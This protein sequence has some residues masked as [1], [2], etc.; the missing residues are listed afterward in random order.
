MIK[1]QVPI[2]KLNEIRVKMKIF[3][4]TLLLITIP[5][6]IILSSSCTKRVTADENSI[7]GLFPAYGVDS[8]V[9]IVNWNVLFS[10]SSFFSTQKEDMLAQII[11]S[12]DVDIIAVQEFP[13]DAEMTRLIAKTNGYAGIINPDTDGFNQNTGYIYK[14]S[15]VTLLRSAPIYTSDGSAFPRSPFTAD[16]V[17]QNSYGKFDVHLVTVHL[18]A[19]SGAT[20]DARRRD[21]NEKLEAYVRDYENTHT[22]KDVIVLGD[23]NDTL[24]DSVVFGSWYSYPNDYLF[25]TI[26]ISTDPAQASYPSYPS[27]ID[28]Q[29]MTSSLYANNGL[30]KTGGTETLL[31]NKYI[32]N[33]SAISDHRPVMSRFRFEKE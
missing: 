16:F 13:S 6:L 21:A 2:D 26:Q 30:Y 31:L 25:A 12:M 24:N 1:L 17:I 8:L 19:S 23:F 22:D 3:F 28:H 7:E 15:T 11:M 5:L 29:V 14:T 20:N 27:F 10:Q 4:K 32:S 9:E 18:K 33:Y